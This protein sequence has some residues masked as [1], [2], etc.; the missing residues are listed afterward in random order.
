[1]LKK[2]SQSEYFGPATTCGK[3]MDGV[4]FPKQRRAFLRPTHGRGS[5]DGRGWG[6]RSGPAKGPGTGVGVV[7]GVRTATTQLRTA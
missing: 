5:G 1:M 6:Q 7:I 4:P 3:K 2:E